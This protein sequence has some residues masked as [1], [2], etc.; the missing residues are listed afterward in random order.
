M[1]EFIAR[2]HA[3]MRVTLGDGT[4][5][6]V[7]AVNKSH[8]FP[9]KIPLTEP[10]SAALK[11]A[12]ANLRMAQEVDVEFWIRKDGTFELHSF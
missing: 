7:E 1:S 11:E 4:A 8:G 5:M 6:A 3:V 10:V 2:I 9:A 12:H